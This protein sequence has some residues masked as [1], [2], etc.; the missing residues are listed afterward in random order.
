MDKRK[1]KK[2][3]VS[4]YKSTPIVLKDE[5]WI[6]VSGGGFGR[7]LLL[8]R[9]TFKKKGDELTG[10]FIGRRA[11]KFGELY[12][13][14][15]ENGEQV[16]LPSSSALKYRMQGVKEGQMVKIIYAGDEVSKGGRTFR[17]FAVKVKK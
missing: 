14:D 11:G 3:T 13:I 17:Q 9:D 8:I 1:A 15:L 10:T 16:T 12:D 7:K 6:D 2:K 5:A 4:A